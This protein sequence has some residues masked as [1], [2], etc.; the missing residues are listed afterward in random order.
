MQDAWRVTSD[1]NERDLQQHA[2]FSWVQ[3]ARSHAF[4]SQFNPAFS[5]LPTASGL[6][7]KWQFFVAATALFNSVQNL[8]GT[9][10]TKQV[11]AG[12]PAEGKKIVLRPFLI[13]WFHVKILQ[14][15][16]LQART[17]ASW[18]LVSA[19]VRLYGAYYIHDKA[20][21]LYHFFGVY[22]ALIARCSVYELAMWTYAI[23][24]LHFVSEWLVFRSAK[25]SRGLIG[26]LIIA[27]E[28]ILSSLQDYAEPSL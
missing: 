18:T 22:N 28:L 17:F 7:P 8:F 12:K 21:A 2:R 5:V 19:I 23:A 15:T 9:A 13:F 16:G 11:Y 14:V 3:N 4:H 26:P 27:R 24:M 10:L 20:Y 1:A 6:L 25:F